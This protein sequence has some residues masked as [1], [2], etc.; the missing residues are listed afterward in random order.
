[1]AKSAPLQSVRRIIRSVSPAWLRPHQQS[2]LLFR[3]QKDEKQGGGITGD[4]PGLGKAA[5]ACAYMVA[6]NEIAARLEPNPIM[7]STLIT[8]PAQLVKK[9]LRDYSRMCGDQSHVLRFGNVF[10]PQ[11]GMPTQKL[12]VSFSRNS[13]TFQQIN[14]A[15]VCNN[16]VII[17][18][19]KLSYSWDSHRDGF[20]SS[21]FLL[22]AVG[23]HFI[24]KTRDKYRALDAALLA[25]SA[26]SLFETF[27]LVCT[28]TF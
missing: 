17:S 25:V 10:Q 18:H 22:A 26:T 24:S 14:G 3:L 11:I 4:A 9:T 1:M 12:N 6:S 8:V 5:L 15:P 19:E 16:L 27:H 28:I 7:G 2:G 20:L 23:R 21:L 13:S